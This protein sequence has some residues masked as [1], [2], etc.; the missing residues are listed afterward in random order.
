MKHDI[1]YKD[2]K[3]RFHEVSKQENKQK[4]WGEIDRRTYLRNQN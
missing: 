3:K 2:W 1:D 4:L